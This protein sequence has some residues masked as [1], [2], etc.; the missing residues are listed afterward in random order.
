MNKKDKLLSFLSGLDNLAVAFSG[1][2]D[3]MLLLKTAS[4]ALPPERLLAVTAR[5]PFF[6]E[7]ETAE[8]AELAQSLG[9]THR[10]ADAAPLDR[11]E[12][13]A[14][15]EDRCY[16]CKKDL[17]GGL[18]ALAAEAGF[19]TVADGGN[20]DDL[21]D[22]R[23][24]ALAVKELGV[25]SP[26]KEAGLTKS[27]IRELSAE[28]GLSTAHKPAFACLASRIPYGQRLTADGL[29]RV[30]RAEDFLFTL[31]F[32]E[33]R[34]RD[35]Q[36]L[37]RIEVGAPERAGFFDLRIMDD[38]QRELSALGFSQVSLDLKGYSRGG[39]NMGLSEE[40]RRAYRTG[41]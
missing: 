28:W 27:D 13:A 11:P 37:A 21:D 14:N 12:I 6:P 23:P 40:S 29:K 5:G 30:E 34:V 7:R 16:H 1:G 18:L 4:L 25:I 2:V 26:L 38:V 20:V 39:L 24:G 19:R 15:P 17:L 9:L 3:S 10:F 35:H 22:Y 41:D 32:K 31:G 36:G 33:V 8:A